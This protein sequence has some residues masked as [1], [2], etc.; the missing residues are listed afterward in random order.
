MS[1]RFVGSC[2]VSPALALAMLLVA[3]AGRAADAA[4]V[5]PRRTAPAASHPKRANARGLVRVAPLLE[6]GRATV[7]RAL[8]AA[9]AGAATPG[10]R[11]A[12]EREE[13][14]PARLTVLPVDAAPSS[15]FGVR[16]DPVRHRRRRMHNGIDFAAHR[17]DVVLSAGAGR[18]V[19]TRP[20]SGYGRI[21]TIDHGD[22]LETRYAH[23]SQV[24][25]GAGEVVAAG[26]PV[27]RV[28]STGRITGPHL[29]FEVWRDGKAIDP[30]EE[31]AIPS[32][33][34][35]A[36]SHSLRDDSVQL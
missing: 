36:K 12:A 23:L 24:D 15:D 22:G 32:R 27:G 4:P 29:H 14:R 25:V 6:R 13:R 21:V 17:G 34:E 1:Q 10:P 19:S 3:S 9:A 16:Q 8:T 33:R 30:R 2:A 7:E 31:L 18:V 20:R 5:T 11:A 28:G 35:W 26:T